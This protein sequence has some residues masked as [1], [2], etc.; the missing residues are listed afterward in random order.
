[1]TKIVLVQQETTCLLERHFFKSFLGI[2]TWLQSFGCHTADFQL[3]LD[4]SLQLSH[5]TIHMPESK[6]Q[7]DKEV[8]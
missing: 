1:M 7:H 6:T 8:V 5:P 3:H 2:V 4:V